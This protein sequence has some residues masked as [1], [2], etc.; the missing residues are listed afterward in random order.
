MNYKLPRFISPGDTIGIVALSMPTNEMRRPRIEA[1]LEEIK[2]LGYRVALGDS[3][4]SQ[5]GYKSADR[6]T[7]RADV[8]RFILDPQVRV[9]LNTT[10]GYNSNEILEGLSYSALAKDPKWIV[11]YS[12]ITTLNMAALSASNIV[13]VNGPML[14][15]IFEDATCLKRLFAQLQGS[16]SE[17]SLPAQ[18][19]EWGGKN[20]RSARPVADHR[21]R[22]AA[23]STASARRRYA[24]SVLRARSTRHP[25]SRQASATALRKRSSARV[26]PRA[27]RPAVRVRR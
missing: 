24:P 20:I 25:A 16:F 10:G 17:L 26:A 18:L 7:R 1:A 22:S 13:S 12:D 5:R 3:V 11:G 4:F 27:I 14:V 9:I 2:K 15:D 21:N 6:A 8:E 19:V 23:R